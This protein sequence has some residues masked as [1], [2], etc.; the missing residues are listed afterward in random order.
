[1]TLTLFFWDYDDAFWGDTIITAALNKSVGHVSAQLD[2]EGNSFYVSHCPEIRDNTRSRKDIIWALNGRVKSERKL[3]SY[4]TD[5]ERRNNKDA[6]HKVELK[7]LNEQKIQAF[8]DNYHKNPPDYHITQNNCATIIAN[9]L[10]RGLSC[11][12]LPGVCILEKIQ[13]TPSELKNI[14]E[15]Y[16]LIN[17]LCIFN[18]FS[19]YINPF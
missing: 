12:K 3:K 17:N 7:G 18:C 11:Y 10:K 14:T 19:K 9:L 5:V 16:F 8:C 6:D 4:T 2:I 1:M 15:E 13:W